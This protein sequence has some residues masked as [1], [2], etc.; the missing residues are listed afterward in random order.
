MGTLHEQQNTFLITSQSIFLRMKNVSDIRCTENQ[1]K[2]FIFNNVFPK[3]MSFIEIMLK[4]MLEP[5][6]PQMTHTVHVDCML[7]N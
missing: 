3:I 5:D 1:T 7:G 4:N 6:K 2:Y